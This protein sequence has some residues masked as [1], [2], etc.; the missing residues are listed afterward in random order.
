MMV[1][2][3]HESGDPANIVELGQTWLVFSFCA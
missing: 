3:D 1:I 2:E